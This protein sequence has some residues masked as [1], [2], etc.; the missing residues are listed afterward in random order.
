MY[1]KLTCVFETIYDV[2]PI[3]SKTVPKLLPVRCISK[4]A[5]ILESCSYRY[6]Q[7]TA[8]KAN[9]RVLISTVI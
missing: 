3:S 4:N 1:V 5:E 6:P 7:A 9:A 8:R 2:G